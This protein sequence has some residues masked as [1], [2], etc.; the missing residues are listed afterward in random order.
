LYD[1]LP[2]HRR[3]ELRAALGAARCRKLVPDQHTPQG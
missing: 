3:D 1:N 2:R